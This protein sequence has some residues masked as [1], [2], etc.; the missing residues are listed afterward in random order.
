MI[1]CT[2][3]CERLGGA[4]NPLP[5][6]NRPSSLKSKHKSDIAIVSFHTPTCSNLRTA[7]ARSQTPNQATNIARLSR[8]LIPPI[9]IGGPI[10]ANSQLSGPSRLRNIPPIVIGGPIEAAVARLPL[11]P[12]SVVIPPIVIGGPIE[13]LSLGY[14]RCRNF[15]FRRLLSAAPLKRTYLRWFLSAQSH[16]ADCYRRPH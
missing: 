6:R 16:S 8:A 11:G 7:N 2:L 9:V 5:T 4:P 14:Q 12:G 10:E 13:A 3:R 15:P 1:Y